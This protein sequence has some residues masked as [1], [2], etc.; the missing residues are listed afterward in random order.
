M[1]F[2]SP[3]TQTRNLY[4][5]VSHKKE[6]WFTLSLQ[7]LLQLTVASDTPILLF[8]LSTMKQRIKISTWDNNVPYFSLVTH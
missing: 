3:L 1:I 6:T 4:F 5:L 8:P 7:F 2:I